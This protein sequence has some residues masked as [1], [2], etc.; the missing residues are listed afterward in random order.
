[1]GLCGLEH[2][3]TA[4]DQHDLIKARALEGKDGRNRKEIG[5][6]TNK[7]NINGQNSRIGRDQDDDM[8]IFD[9]AEQGRNTPLSPRIGRI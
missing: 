1:M 3:S 7:N 9:E 5:E 2:P 4:H 6:K 8:L